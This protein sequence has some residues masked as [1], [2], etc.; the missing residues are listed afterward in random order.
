MSHK[1][2]TDEY[3][4]V[5][6]GHGYTEAVASAAAAKL[7]QLNVQAMDRIKNTPGIN[8]TQAIRQ[9]WDKT[10]NVNILGKE[11]AISQ[12]YA[13]G[14]RGVG[15]EKTQFNVQSRAQ[16]IKTSRAHATRIEKQENKI[17]KA[18][19]RYLKNH[20]ELGTAGNPT[21]RERTPMYAAMMAARDASRAPNT[22]TVDKI[23]Q[24]ATTGTQITGPVVVN[25][26]PPTVAP[27]MLNNNEHIQLGTV[28]NT[29]TGSSKPISRY[30]STIIGCSF[31]G[32][33]DIVPVDNSYFYI[34]SSGYCF[35]KCIEYIYPEK[36][37]IPTEGL[38]PYGTAYLTLKKKLKLLGYKKL[39]KVYRAC[40]PENGPDGE[41]EQ[42]DLLKVANKMFFKLIK[43]SDGYDNK[44][45]YSILILHTGEFQEYHAVV[46]KK[47][48]LP[49]QLYTIIWNHIKYE[50]LY[51]LT[52]DQKPLEVKTEVRPYGQYMFTY[53]IE[54]YVIK[55]NE[56]E[57]SADSILLV[58]IGVSYNLID[59]DCTNGTDDMEKNILIKDK[60]IGEDCLNQMIESIVLECKRLSLTSIFLIAHNGGN[61]DNIYLKGLGNLTIESQIKK[62]RI[63]KIV[64]VHKDSGIKIMAI[65]SFSF[66]QASLKNSAKYF[67][68]KDNKFSCDI[69]GKSREWFMDEANKSW[70][71]YMEQDTKVLS[72]I[73]LNFEQ[74]LRKWGTSLTL[75]TGIPSVAWK[76][77]QRTCPL[78]KR[79]TVPK[80]PAVIQFMSDARYGGRVIHWLKEY[81][82]QAD[83]KYGL[84]CVDGNNLYPSSMA[85]GLF[86]IDKYQVYNTGL[87]VED[88]IKSIKAGKLSI[89]EVTLNVNNQRYPLLPYRTDKGC[90][91]YCC[92][93]IRG[94]Y[95]SVD[96]EEALN[97][98]YTLVET[99]RGVLWDASGDIFFKLVSHLFLERANLKANAN[100]MEYAM[101]IML[102]STY[103]YTGLIIDSCST[104]STNGI[105]DKQFQSVSI[106][107]LGNGQYEHTNKYNHPVTDKPIHIAAFILS[108]ARKIMNNNIRKIGPQN[109]AYGD[110]DSL[111]VY[112]DKIAD[113]I[114]N[115]KTEEEDIKLMEQF[116]NKEHVKLEK[117]YELT[118][119][120]NKLGCIKND[121]GYTTTIVDGKTIKKSV[122][123]KRA[124]FLDIKR[125]YI[126]FDD[127]D[128]KGCKYKA[129]FTGLNFINKT[130]RS[131]KN[132]MNE[133]DSIQD[134]I[135]RLYESLLQ[136]PNVPIKVIQEKWKRYHSGV[137]IDDQE[138]QFVVTPDVRNIWFGNYSYPLDFQFD[139]PYITL[140]P[141]TKWYDQKKSIPEYT[142]YN[143]V[144]SGLRMASNF[145]PIYYPPY[146]N[147]KRELPKKYLDIEF[148]C[149]CPPLLDHK[150]K[151][152]F[153]VEVNEDTNETTT[154]FYQVVNYTDTYLFNKYGPYKQVYPPKKFAF[155]LAISYRLYKHSFNEEPIFNPIISFDDV[156][157]KLYKPSD[158]LFN[159]APSRI[160]VYEPLPPTDK[161][162][163]DLFD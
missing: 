76:L 153:I 71:E 128:L 100:P 1:N 79:V 57:A 110:C 35:L 78:L 163:Y 13:L 93:T 134:G 123:V 150:V 10:A 17:T 131:L 146:K 85:F 42:I 9:L 104:F 22:R 8:R 96:I 103:G 118:A 61:F 139:Q 105:A 95:T 64:F 158:I 70:I 145:I 52:D 120:S 55:L 30:M 58:P 88:Y 125:C 160:P 129:K 66:T 127:S 130:E 115:D 15:T 39:P 114:E 94:I 151:S 56:D 111:Y 133:G 89:F 62:G 18:A 23:V 20:P 26:R 75:N 34:P 24:R 63:K 137:G 12:L 132:Y 19:D 46:Y 28:N 82:K 117:G 25:A 121:Y 65:D 44:S 2:T 112:G 84:I 47:K 74:I 83:E 27:P 29:I 68:L 16:Y 7:A 157:N 155:V 140:G 36:G 161:P 97:D 11:N 144:M 14:A 59:L 106:S 108:Y 156:Y 122:F 152:D 91:V 99:H 148:V 90:I 51:T 50:R 92:G 48:Q 135:V 43:S 67:G 60:F 53:D 54:A 41:I 45:P 143:T 33:L 80:D 6:E 38:N 37:K 3:Y 72:L 87:P 126:E 73:C 21:D 98:G 154:N 113:I 86:P 159:R 116:K 147:I 77:I 124:I 162:S 107:K 31:K 40:Y 4:K 119:L 81:V 142:I 49:D 69:A 141:L 138:M 109:I 32:L 149:T 101:K 102:N 5:I 136:N